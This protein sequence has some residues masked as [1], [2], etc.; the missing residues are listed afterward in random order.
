M[1]I[2][3]LPLSYNHSMRALF[4]GVVLLAGGCTRT[5]HVGSHEDAPRIPEQAS[6]P[7]GMVAAEF[8]KGNHRVA[9]RLLSERPDLPDTDARARYLAGYAWMRL[10]RPDAAKSFLD[11]CGDF[12]GY[13]GWE[14]T[15]GLLRRIEA[16]ERLRPPAV[17]GGGIPGIRIFADETPWIRE[18]VKSLPA[19]V[20][21]ARAVLG[22]DLPP[23]DF[24]LFRAR[25]QYERFYK[26]L[27]GVEVATAWQNGTGDSNV[28]VFCQEDREGRILGRPG[29]LRGLGD[30]LHEYTHSLLNSFYGDRYLRHVPQ[31]LD[32]GLSD[33][34]ARPYYGELFESSAVAIRKFLAKSVPP[35]YEDLCRRL[36]E[37]DS[38][39]RYGMARFMVEELMKSRET[40]VIRDILR[41]A[42]PPGDFD[43]A[44]L[45]ATGAI[46]ADL[47][48]RVLARFR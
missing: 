10:H 46:P 5:V 48:E 1:R 2:P 7:V 13:P 35:A 33:F 3:D 28:V 43:Q 40:K 29:A 6:D 32:E 17:D 47:R 34:V 31:W 8:S 22:E 14:T 9:L 19:F 25:E 15:S 30:V 44:I 21:R 27:F 36:Y 26:A 45:G 11:A 23:V 41:R 39:V 42:A 4:F 38:F 24:Y 20:D 37:R 18:V 16:V 12:A